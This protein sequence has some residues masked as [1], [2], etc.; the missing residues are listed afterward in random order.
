MEEEL[1]KVSPS[2]P[3]DFKA[4][5]QHVR[6]G[7][8]PASRVFWWPILP[9]LSSTTAVIDT[10]PDS[11]ACATR[12]ATILKEPLL[13]MRH[14]IATLEGSDDINPEALDTLYRNLAYV[15]VHHR[16]IE[17]EA[18]GQAE[19]LLKLL[20]CATRRIDLAC[21]TACTVLGEPDRFGRFD[22]KGGSA[23]NQTFLELLRAFCPKTHTTLH[24]LGA[25][26]NKYLDL[27]FAGLF[28]EL[29]PPHLV[30]ML[31]DAFLLEGMKILLRFALGLVF[32]YKP[33]IKVRADRTA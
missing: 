20:L 10:D 27:M 9:T 28:T 29:L 25:L 18:L 7:L 5:K 30:F 24:A 1:D 23:L 22:Y 8:S 26:D 4:L 16:K 14:Q 12:L 33:H 17:A 21:F 19:V 2:L 32:A 3:V 31:V 15:L 6:K 13:D 11:I